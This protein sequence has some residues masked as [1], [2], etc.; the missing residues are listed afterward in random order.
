M[1]TKRT[2]LARQKSLC[3]TCGTEIQTLATSGR[4]MHK[5]GEAA[6]AH[7][8]KHAKFGGDASVNNCVIVCDSCHY[9]IHEGGR[10]RHGTVV[11]EISDFPYYYG[12][13]DQM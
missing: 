3:A 9:C 13:P 8:I 1:A 6:H 4:E 10:Y 5:F 12:D 7:H 11:G 2:A